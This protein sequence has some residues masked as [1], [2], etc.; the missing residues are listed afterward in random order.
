VTPLLEVR[1]LVAGYGE[2]VVIRGLDLS[3]APGEVFTVL[4]VNGAGKTTL[5]RALGGMIPLRGGSIMFDGRDIGR[6][7]TVARAR[8]GVG[9][10]PEGRALY[11][12]L[13]VHE[14]LVMGGITLR[15]S[16]AKR[17]MSELEERFPLLRTRRNFPVDSLSGGEQQILAIARALMA[18]PRL[19]LLDEP[20]TGLAPLIVRQV[21]TIVEE[22]RSEGM[23]VILV[24]QNVTIALKVADRGMVIERGAVAMEGSGEELRSADRLAAVYLGRE[25]EATGSAHAVPG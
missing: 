1:G 16:V 19:L 9:H 5:L 4:G 12:G 15:R 22:L 17:R 23:G 13:S 20:S 18:H 8:M 11:P 24:E 3:V 7:S 25:T 14:H 2:S 21:L 6:K 10:V